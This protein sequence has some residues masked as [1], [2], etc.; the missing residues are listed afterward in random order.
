MVLFGREQE[1]RSLAKVFDEC[2]DARGSVVL[3]EGEISSGRTELLKEFIA[4]AK[5]AGASVLEATGS[6]AER[7]VPLSAITQLLAAAP[8]WL[9]TENDTL[10]LLWPANESTSWPEPW[11]GQMPVSLELLHNIYVT[12]R[13][14]AAVHPVVVVIDDAHYLDTS[15]Q[16]CISYVA[17]RISSAGIMI[18]LAGPSADQREYNEFIAELAKPPYSTTIGLGPLCIEA[19]ASAIEDRMGWSAGNE[20]VRL[21]HQASGGSP[22]FAN[23][24]MEDTAPT[25]DDLNS[26]NPVLHAGPHYRQACERFVYA[27]DHITRDTLLAIAILE[28]DSRP[29]LIA[30]L[31]GS[32][33]ESTRQ[34]VNLL[35]EVG[36]LGGTSFRHTDARTTVLDMMS[37]A[38]RAN[39]RS[40]AAR[41][42]HDDGADPR[43][44]A[45]QLAAVGERLDPWAVEVLQ[46]AAE[47]SVS[48]GDLDSAIAY[49][50][51][52][53][54]A[55][56]D[57][58]SRLLVL[59]RLAQV[60]WQMNPEKAGRHLP[61]LVTGLRAGKL[62]GP[63]ATVPVG[64]LLWAGRID[65]AVDI[66]D[67]IENRL[68]R[69]G[70]ETAAAV[71]E[72]RGLLSHAFPLLLPGVVETRPEQEPAA[73]H[74][75]TAHMDAA[76]LLA[77]AFR[78]GSPDEVSAGA[79][80]LLQQCRADIGSGRSAGVA[81]SGLAALVYADDLGSAQAWCERLEN[82][83]RLL[84]TMQ[85][86]LVAIRSEIS[87]R[88]GDL[89]QA[90]EWALQALQR[91]SREGW[92][93]ALALPISRVI[94]T[95]ASMG[96]LDEA[97]RAIR[98]P[99]PKGT[100]RTI[101]GLH[102]LHARGRY[103]AAAGK[104][105]QAYEAFRACGRTMQEWGVD[106]PAVVGWRGEAAGALCRLHRTDEARTL[107]NQQL[108]MLDG[109]PTRTRGITLRLAAGLAPLPQRQPMLE[110]AVELLERAGD[111]LE[112]ALALA[113]LASELD[114]KGLSPQ[115]DQAHERVQDLSRSP[116][117][118]S[119]DRCAWPHTFDP[120]LCT[121]KRREALSEAEQRVATL[122]A[123]G[124]SNREIAEHL[125]V[126]VSTVE[127]HLTHIYRKLLV[128]RR[129]ELSLAL[130]QR[131]ASV[132]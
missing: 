35:G 38:N 126:T 87:L 125:F 77:S 130:G 56:T 76:D 66:I 99:V 32:D 80:Q 123:A 63:E 59:A 9:N 55:Q 82:G 81:L 6:K 1:K 115:R 43:S 57:E 47:L 48:G 12:L 13:R 107:V 62:G 2:N 72:T 73:V 69:L 4:L 85:S 16:K 46:S 96:R 27:C 101:I 37:P 44:V 23:A 100:S 104:W 109:R 118:S 11:T 93:I 14:A 122:A 74:I 45:A 58:N 79:E 116:G 92:G 110:E 42:L 113:D 117:L 22:A 51:H 25:R 5:A 127:Q 39:L 68:D 124:H 71:A 24:L 70:T 67:R 112:L 49:L 132:T 41:A 36:L 61:E 108:A 19:L 84:P 54:R 10:Q 78:G 83:P 50:R 102:Y 94:I 75:A 86:F 17:H 88:L 114:Y 21:L 95:A 20:F 52:A 106:N 98:I 8:E 31:T 15:S 34:A 33:V 40:K 60:E 105:R 131:P 111:R 103:N 129:S 121:R 89:Q 7:A 119:L 91:M 30:Q 18:L 120:A 26:A 64:Q 28:S 128:R 97:A 53:H 3:V 65:E 90:H 29:E